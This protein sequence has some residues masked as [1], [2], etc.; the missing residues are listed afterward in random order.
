MSGI[1]FRHFLRHQVRTTFFV[2]ASVLGLFFVLTLLE[3][4]GDAGGGPLAALR[5]T[6]LAMPA[7][8]HAALPAC[9]ALGCAVSLALLDGRR[10]LAMMRILGLRRRRLL[11]WIAAASLLWVALHAATAELLLPKSAALSR[12][13][14]SQR[15]G[16]LVTAADSV[17][18]KTA[19]GYARLD[20]VTPQGGLLR[21]VW[22][23]DYGGADGGG[24]LRSVRRARHASYANEAWSLNDVDEATV[25]PGGW[26]FASRPLAAWP[27]GP[28]PSLL[29]S[30]AIPP[31]SLELGKLRELAASLRALEQNT[32]QL[33]LL[34]WSRLGDELALVGL[35][36]A[37]LAL[38]RFRTRSSPGA[39]RGAVIAA[40]VAVLLFHYFQIIA[41]QAA[42]DLGL[43]GAAGAL[44]PLAGLVPLAAASRLFAS[45]A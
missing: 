35:A 2:V 29:A 42:V 21:D 16:S 24:G 31:A 44:L 27:G 26:T 14:E 23:F 6:M 40:I 20:L 12:D 1:L 11:L 3:N 39:T 15:S 19:D 9:A 34:I 25:G 38:A 37:M 4:L 36:L 43:P 10:E 18:L 13:L 5:A 41:K 8:L 32:V 28:D 30:F 45:R 7:V 22:I 33:D 17:W